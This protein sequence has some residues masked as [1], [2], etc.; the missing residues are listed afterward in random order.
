MIYYHLRFLSVLAEYTKYN[1]WSLRR[2]LENYLSTDWLPPGKVRKFS[3][4]RNYVPPKYFWK[5]KNPLKDEFTPMRG[6]HDIF[7]GFKS[8]EPEPANVLLTG[9]VITVFYY[10]PQTKLRE[11][12]VS[13]MFVSPQGEVVS[14]A[15]VGMSKV[16]GG[17]YVQGMGM[18]EGWI[19][20]VYGI[21]P[22][23]LDLG[24]PSP[25]H[26]YRHLVAAT[27]ACAV[28]KW[29]VHLLLECF[30]PASVLEKTVT[31]N[32]V[33]FLSKLTHFI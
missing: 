14:V 25:L 27:K 21:H 31:I 26:S 18:S 32:V 19:Y 9:E 8:K 20:Q 12:M 13:Q 5:L 15:G 24:Y 2:R 29:V 28:H 22:L 6:I 1:K 23:A 4:R 16:G 17:E 33:S 3:L 10:R 30:L 7:S 11:V